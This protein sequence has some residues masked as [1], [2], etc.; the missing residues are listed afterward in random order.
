MKVGDLVFHEE[1][2]QTGVVSSVFSQTSPET[3]LVLMG[4][5]VTV[6]TY[7]EELEVINEVE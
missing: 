6:T 1:L 2:E 3:L 7:E 5:G 4:D